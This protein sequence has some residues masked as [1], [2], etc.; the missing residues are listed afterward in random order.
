M[1]LALQCAMPSADGR[2][3]SHLIDF[4]A[5]TS[6]RSIPVWAVLLLALVGLTLL[7]RVPL[8]TRFLNDDYLFLEQA[9]SQPLSHSL[10]TLDALGNYYRPLSR[11][12]YFAVLTPV[13][14]GDPW[15]FHAFNYALFLAAL[16]LLADLLLALLPLGGAVAGVV[17][18]ALLPFQRVVLMWVS[19][20]QDLLALAGTLAALALYRRGRTGWAL[21]AA[22][23]ALASKESALPLVVALIAWDALVERRAASAIA[24]RIA[25]FAA[26]TLVWGAL[27]LAMRASNAAAPLHL[28]IASFAA[29]YL[30]L[31]QALSGIEKPRATLTTLVQHAP[32]VLPLVALLPLTLLAFRGARD[33]TAAPAPKEPASI[34][35]TPRGAIG[36]ALVWLVA[37][38]AVT[39]PVAYSWSAYY[40]T[41]A[42][43]GGAVLVG[44]LMQHARAPGLAMLIVAL[45]WM[46]AG[47]SATRGFAVED[48]P[49]AAN[50]HLT[51][52]Y[53]ERAAALT[54]SM[55]AQLVRLEPDPPADAR[56]FFAT[57]PPFAGFQ[58]GN[59]AL[60]RWIYRK[61]QIQSHFMSQFSD[62]TAGG[63]PCRFLYWDGESLAP[64]YNP[65]TEVY[66]QVGCD[67][68]LLDRLE[69]GLYAFRRGAA[70]GESRRD[71]LYWI[72]WG[73]LWAGRRG[74]AERAWT[75]LGFSDDSLRW[76]THLRDAHNALVDGDTLE[77][78]RQLVAAIQYGVG[79]PEAHAVLGELLTGRNT[80]YGL[81]ELKV[82]TRL[83]PRDWVARRALALGLAAVQLD[84]PAR[85]ELATLITQRPE[86]RGDST[87]AALQH[88][89]TLRAPR[90]GS[91]AT[92]Q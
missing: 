79:R 65:G 27:S 89:L 22:A 6:A 69:R 83:N 80:K 7:Y 1:V 19:C 92:L 33:G 25:P 63:H 73:E 51:S 58:M 60:V 3:P 67:L 84:E 21:C 64:L 77:S 81:L 54:D 10:T 31:L 76:I 47:S 42:A 50:S 49:W 13:S 5:V 15:V 39:G 86:L 17:Y 18:F 16:A 68:L 74:A 66:F 91:T 61:P 11:Q 53:F 57:L 36:F 40:Y 82:A 59:G 43:V 35:P 20:S 90:S 72:G 9:R 12:L 70:A 88:E 29:A 24:R 23:A 85:E 28:S 34:A 46:H 26:L 38:T 87:I 62:S 75:E 52:A 4:A 2:A 45:L 41:L 48:S 30:H 55:A 44:A 37:F 56:F 32:A 78:K 71:L 8:A 14:G